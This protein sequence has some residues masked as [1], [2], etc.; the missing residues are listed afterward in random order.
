MI[1]PAGRVSS[2]NWDIIWNVRM[3]RVALA[4]IVGAMLSLAGASYQG[5]FR[6][7]LVDP[8]LLGVAAGAG[9]GATIIF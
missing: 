4:G 7:P 5:V 2:A 9:L 6:N 3:P 8:Y 1:G